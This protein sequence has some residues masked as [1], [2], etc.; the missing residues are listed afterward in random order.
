MESNNYLE[1]EDAVVELQSDIFEHIADKM[2]EAEAVSSKN[3]DPESD[4]AMT[5]TQPEL[6]STFLELM[7]SK[8]FVP[9]TGE[10]EQASGG[11]VNLS[12]MLK[13]DVPTYDEWVSSIEYDYITS[14]AEAYDYL[15]RVVDFE[16][17]DHAVEHG[18]RLLDDE[19]TIQQLE[20]DGDGAFREQRKINLGVMGWAEMCHLMGVEYGSEK[21]VKLARVLFSRVDETATQASHDLAEDRGTFELWDESKYASPSENRNWFIERTHQRP[22]DWEDG[23]EMRNQRVTVSQKAENAAVLAETTPGVEPDSSERFTDVTNQDTLDMKE[24]YQNS[25]DSDL[26]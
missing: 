9:Y 15:E 17:L 25:V 6:R 23:Y 11:C 14:Q 26:A 3:H 18:V 10:G 13:E 20:S 4:E 8:T 2:M 5:P 24:V 21:S 1:L 7:Q 16:K 22:G 19:L 12:L